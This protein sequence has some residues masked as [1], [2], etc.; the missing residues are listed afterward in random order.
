MNAG[1]PRNLWR[2]KLDPNSL[3]ED[4]DASAGLDGK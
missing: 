3:C 4:V 2:Q 1:A